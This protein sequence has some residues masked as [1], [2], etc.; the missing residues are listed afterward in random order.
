ML[1]RP[2]SRFAAG[3]S[4]INNKAVSHVQCHLRPTDPRFGRLGFCGSVRVSASHLE[5]TFHNKNIT[6]ALLASLGVTSLENLQ[7]ELRGVSK[8]LSNLANATP[9]WDE[10]KWSPRLTGSPQGK[11]LEFICSEYGHTNAAQCKIWMEKWLRLSQDESLA[12]QVE[13]VAA[14]V[15]LLVMIEGVIRAYKMPDVTRSC[16]KVVSY[17]IFGLLSVCEEKID[18]DTVAAYFSPSSSL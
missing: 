16:E 4:S 6:M 7:R 13:N 5:H 12:N 18:I 11:R 10:T 9:I 1:E 17:C 14:L 15:C 2:L 8:C 3:H